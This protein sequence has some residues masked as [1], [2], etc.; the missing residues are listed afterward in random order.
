MPEEH[1]TIVVDILD[2]AQDVEAVEADYQERI[3]AHDDHM[4]CSPGWFWNHP[5]DMQQEDGMRQNYCLKEIPRFCRLMEK[6]AYAFLDGFSMVTKAEDIVFEGITGILVIF[7]EAPR[8][9]L[10]AEVP[11]VEYLQDWNYDPCVYHIGR[12]F[13]FGFDAFVFVYHIG[14]DFGFGFDA[15]VFVYHIGRDLGFGFDAFVF[16]YHIGRDLG[17]GFDAFQVGF[18]FAQ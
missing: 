16:V 12:D 6:E 11:S 4:S 7:L 18:F 14:R 2:P 5:G 9:T 15:F 13:G 10:L 8:T 1:E 17:F 3:Q